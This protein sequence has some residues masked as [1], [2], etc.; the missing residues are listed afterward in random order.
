MAKL[1]QQNLFA[2]DDSYSEMTRIDEVS[3]VPY[4]YA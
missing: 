1:M 2:D 3:E 4:Q